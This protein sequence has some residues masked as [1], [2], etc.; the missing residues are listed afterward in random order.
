M[1]K[2]RCKEKSS[3]MGFMLSEITKEKQEPIA[4]T[5]TKRIWNLVSWL[6]VPPSA[7]LFPSLYLQGVTEHPEIEEGLWTCFGK[8]VAKLEGLS[9]LPQVS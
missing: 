5:K 4:R 8:D 3:Q 2:G 1:R 7:T 9:H 6:L